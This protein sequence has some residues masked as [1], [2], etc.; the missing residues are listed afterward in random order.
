MLHLTKLFFKNEREIKTLSN[1]QKW[2]ELT[3]DLAYE[4]Y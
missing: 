2:R 4:K 3:L 1:K